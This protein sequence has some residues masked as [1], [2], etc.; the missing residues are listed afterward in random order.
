[1][2]WSDLQNDLNIL[3]FSHPSDIVQLI[4]A[5]CFISQG[6]EIIMSQH[7]LEREVSISNPEVNIFETLY[8]AF[9]DTIPNAKG[10]LKV[11][12]LLSLGALREDVL[13]FE[14]CLSDV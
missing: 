9:V 1:M 6:I 7:T 10:V 2:F 14:I 13:F 11:R 8:T 5:N 12:R 3:I 4:L